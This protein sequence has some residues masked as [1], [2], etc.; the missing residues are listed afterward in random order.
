MFKWFTYLTLLLGVP[1]EFCLVH[2]A[3]EWGCKC[4]H[5]SAGFLRVMENLKNLE[6][7]ENRMI[8][9]KVIDFFCK[10]A[11]V[12]EKSCNPSAKSLYE[13]CNVVS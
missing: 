6:N 3:S 4:F 12:M 11:K 13:P 10:M 5:V 8:Q 9:G 7:L 1:T 2:L